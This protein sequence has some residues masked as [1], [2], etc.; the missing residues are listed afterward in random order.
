[1]LLLCCFHVDHHVYCI[2]TLVWAC[3]LKAINK[4]LLLLLKE[5]T[6][7][8]IE[9][10]HKESVV[11]FLTRVTIVVTSGAEDAIL[12]TAVYKRQS[13]SLTVC[14]NHGKENQFT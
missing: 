4:L 8:L 5:L 9:V 14:T 7:T 6:L 12:N 11:T 2:C 3:G 13:T 1:M 10:V